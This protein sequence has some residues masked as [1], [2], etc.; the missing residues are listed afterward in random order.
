VGEW[1]REWFG[2]TYL[3][4]YRH[5][6]RGEATGFVATLLDRFEVPTGGRVLDVACGAGRH[7]LALAERGLCVLG[8]DLSMPLLQQAGKARRRSG[9]A[10]SI[11]LVQGDMR[12]LPVAV[13]GWADLALN[14]F[15]A[16]GYFDSEEEDRRVLR[17]MATALRPGG[18]L[19]LDFVHRPFVLANLVP[20]DEEE[21]E[22]MSI[23]QERRLTDGDRRIEK[24]I[25]LHQTDGR[26][27]T[28]RE[29]VRLYAPGDLER[30]LRETGLEPLAPWGDYDGSPLRPDSPRCIAFGRRP[31]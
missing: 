15:T 23:V 12:S 30:L 22:G 27:E 17:G 24:T 18:R 4:L 25:R 13:S 31:T 16:L 26:E 11:L 3:D 8:V 20:R 29:S 9:A 7:A 6:D 5:R 2:A 21:R 19:V 10:D 1:Y 28:Y 14:L